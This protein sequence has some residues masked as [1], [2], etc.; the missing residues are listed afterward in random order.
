[1]AS[2]AYRLVVCRVVKFGISGT[3]HGPDMVDFHRQGVHD[4]A[5]ADTAM[6][7][8]TAE[9]VVGLQQ[10]PLTVSLPPRPI[11]AL[12]RCPPHP[13]IR[14]LFLDPV[15]GAESLAMRHQGRTHGMPA[16]MS[17][18]HRHSAGPHAH[19][20]HHQPNPD[21]DADGMFRQE[22]LDLGSHWNLLSY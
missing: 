4:P 14:P 16:G 10:I 3:F 22:L 5:T 20:E 15:R 7:T 17:G 8:R 2:P 9:D 6:Q 12:R 18:Q 19:Q 21:A 13:G 1:M 11:A